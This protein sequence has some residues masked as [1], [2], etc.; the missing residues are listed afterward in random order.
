MF[1]VKVS[2]NDFLRRFPKAY[3]H[4]PVFRSRLVD[5]S[6]SGIGDVSSALETVG[7]DCMLRMRCFPPSILLP[8]PF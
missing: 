1:S 8:I 7:D 3:T 6:I 5:V 2:L 4:Q